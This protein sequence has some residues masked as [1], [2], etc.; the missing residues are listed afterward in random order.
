VGKADEHTGEEIRITGRW[1]VLYDGDCGLCKWLLAGLLRW[2][3][4]QTLHPIALQR[5]EAAELL[6]DLPPE[7]R[8]ASWHL[9]TPGGE[10]YSGGAA[11]PPLIGLLPKG[12][13]VAA[14]FA[15]I[16]GTTDSGYRWVAEHRS[17][18]S[19]LVPSR[20]KRAASELVRRRER[21]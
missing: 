3:R 15:A 14:L 20:A 5:P 4:T 6:K 9:I 2:D 17:L 11:L 19:K 12:R 13:P 21:S 8:M 16:P 10:R 1:L 7:E 18:L